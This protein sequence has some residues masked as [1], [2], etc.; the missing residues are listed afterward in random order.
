MER[1]RG[2]LEAAEG[3]PPT[4]LSE[5]IGNFSQPLVSPRTK[6]NSPSVS[7]RPV[8]TPE[9]FG[10][11][12][13]PTAPPIVTA[14]NEPRKIAPHSSTNSGDARQVGADITGSI[15]KLVSREEQPVTIA[16]PKSAPRRLAAPRGTAGWPAAYRSGG[17][18]PSD[19][20]RSGDCGPR[21]LFFYHC[22]SVAAR[23]PI[24]CGRRHGCG[25][26]RACGCRPP[27]TCRSEQHRGSNPSCYRQWLCGSGY[28]GAQ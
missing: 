13:L 11:S 2:S 15:E 24:G 28:V 3:P 10:G 27:R 26:P 23:W 1:K 12:V 4:S 14:S 20:A 7:R 6:R 18:E 17:S 9:E 5:R 8:D 25:E 19:A 22:H 21:G 16:P